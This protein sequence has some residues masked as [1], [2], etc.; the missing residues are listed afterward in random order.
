MGVRLPCRAG[1]GRGFGKSPIP[2][3]KSPD[4]K[5]GRSPWSRGAAATKVVPGQTATPHRE[6]PPTKE[7]PVNEPKTNPTRIDDDA[8][9]E[10]ERDQPWYCNAVSVA[11]AYQMCWMT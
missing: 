6:T 5:W 10:A 11:C 2:V 1:D 7:N 3:R 4:R 8:V 9:R